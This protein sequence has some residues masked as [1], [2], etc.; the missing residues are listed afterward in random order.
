M[1]Q[2][3]SVGESELDGDVLVAQH[4]RLEIRFF[5]TTI[6]ADGIAGIVGAITVIIIILVVYI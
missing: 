1:H 3:D 2:F 6:C 4:Q 5:G